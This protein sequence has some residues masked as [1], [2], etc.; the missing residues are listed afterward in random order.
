M[1]NPT[2][3]IVSTK[4]LA[5]AAAAGILICAFVASL[6]VWGCGTPSPDAPTSLPPADTPAVS[7]VEA[8]GAATATLRL[9][10]GEQSLVVQPRFL[11]GG[12]EVS[13]IAEDATGCT[14]CIDLEVSLDLRGAL[15]A[16]LV[17]TAGKDAAAGAARW[18]PRVD[19]EFRGSIPARDGATGDASDVCAAQFGAPRLAV[20]GIPLPLEA[21]GALGGASVTADAT[22]VD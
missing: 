17:H 14:V 2:R 5:Q 22:P 11:C 12:N 6:L 4:T 15:L 20:L 19:A 10:G 18:L 16:A 1:S 3:S 21:F 9:Y 13:A 7:D 8:S